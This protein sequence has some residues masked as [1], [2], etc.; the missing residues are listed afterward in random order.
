M[1]QCRALRELNIQGTFEGLADLSLLTQF[2]HLEKLRLNG[3]PVRR[4]QAVGSCSQLRDFEALGCGRLESVNGLQRCGQLRTLRLASCPRLRGM[5]P[6]AELPR[7]KK[8]EL[9]DLPQQ[10][11]IGRMGDWAD[12]E[13]FKIERCP[14]LKSAQIPRVRS[15]RL[16]NFQ[17]T[18]AV[19]EPSDMCLIHKGYIIPLLR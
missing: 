5:V 10:V 11:S 3:V 1:A 2:L 15:R 7:L 6:L 12:L 16:P 9:R 17:A 18:N 8:L 13:S 4:I 19:F 14:Y